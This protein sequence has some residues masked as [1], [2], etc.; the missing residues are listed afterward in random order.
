MTSPLES[1]ELGKEM[2]KPSQSR[3]RTLSAAMR[4][5]RFSSLYWSEEWEGQKMLRCVGAEC[6]PSQA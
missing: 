1:P 5:A 6:Q 4:E 2:P 3:P